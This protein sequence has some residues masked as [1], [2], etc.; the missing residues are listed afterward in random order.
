MRQVNRGLARRL[1]GDMAATDPTR[2]SF[3]HRNAQVHHLGG[4]IGPELMRELIADARL[5]DATDLSA[6]GIMTRRS[7]V[8]LRPDQEL[9]LADGRLIPLCDAPEK[10]RVHC[11]VH[12]DEN[13][14]AVVIRNRHGENGIF[15]SSCAKSYWTRAHQHEDY[16]PEE[17]VRTARAVAAAAAAQS[18]GDTQLNR[19][20]ATQEQ[21]AGCR[22]RIVS[23]QAAPAVLQPGIMLVRSDKGTGKTEALKRLSAGAKTVLLVG[24]RRTLIRGSCKRLNLRCYLDE[25]KAAKSDKQPERDRAS[26]QDFLAEDKDEH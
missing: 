13:P 11:P 7:T 8:V 23:G 2:I 22:V 19:G 25:N 26:L 20:G 18:A 6:H 21:L 5:P 12:L 4:A 16:D 1:G 17:F 9:Q 10:A 15:C 3:G 24:H 14:S